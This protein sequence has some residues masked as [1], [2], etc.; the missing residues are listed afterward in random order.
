MDGKDHNFVAKCSVR[1]SYNCM[2]GHFALVIS[3]NDCEIYKPENA[4]A[5]RATPMFFTVKC[6]ICGVLV[7][8]SDTVASAP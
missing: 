1:R 8:D 5:K 3:E 2:T 7:A 4:R 6:A